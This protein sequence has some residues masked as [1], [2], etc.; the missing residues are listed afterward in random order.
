LSFK[1]F[2][3]P[4]ER[5]VWISCLVFLATTC[6]LVKIWFRLKKVG[7]CAWLYLPTILFEQDLK[8]PKELTPM[9]VFGSFSLIL[10]FGCSQLTNDYRGMVTTDLT[11]P[12][13]ARTI[14]TID[15][16]LGLGFKILVKIDSKLMDNLKNDHREVTIGKG[17]KE[18]FYVNVISRSP[19]TLDQWY[20]QNI[21]NRRANEFISQVGNARNYD[22]RL[23]ND[24]KKKYDLWLKNLAIDY[25][26]PDYSSYVI[27]SLLIV[28][29][30]YL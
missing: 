7:D 23:T 21:A 6:I 19:E 8:F 16:A 20:L 29:A 27:N 10:I 9:G 14:E 28:V 5:A 4:F 24:T 13:P 2:T 25:F 1:V 17:K 22:T 11:A 12:L 26:A 3:Q 18:N 30:E 15:E